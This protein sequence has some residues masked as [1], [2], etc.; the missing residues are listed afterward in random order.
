ML[1]VVEVSDFFKN[2]LPIDSWIISSHLLL[3]MVC[4]E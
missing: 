3:H 2:Q 1:R 4:N